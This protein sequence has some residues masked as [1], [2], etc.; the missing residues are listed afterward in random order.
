MA[1]ESFGCVMSFVDVYMN[2]VK[3][4]THFSLGKFLYQWCEYRWHFKIQITTWRKNHTVG[5][6]YMRSELIL[7]VDKDL[8][9]SNVCSNWFEPFDIL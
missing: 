3:T 2:C 6:L 4:M 7:T 1:K 8:S 9:I 5:L